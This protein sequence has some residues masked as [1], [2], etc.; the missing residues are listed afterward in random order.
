MHRLTF[1]GQK[2][3]LQIIYNE[4][5][6]EHKHF[7]KECWNITYQIVPPDIH[8]RNAAE[9]TNFTFK[10]HF[11][12]IL[13]GINNAFPKYLWDLL[14]EQAD[15]TLNLL[16]Q[17]TL[18][19]RISAWAYYNVPSESNATLLGPIGCR[20]IIHKNPS[21]RISWDFRGKDGF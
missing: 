4:V 14:S 2:F 5:S 6:S 1:R 10:D 21:T 11:L 3:N 8:Q 7:I 12:S 20:V 15:L 16:L 17:S 18:N 13:A 19:P 9:C